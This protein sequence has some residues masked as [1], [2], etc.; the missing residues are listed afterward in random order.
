MHAQLIS[1]VFHATVSWN[2]YWG[3]GRTVP[4]EN[5]NYFP[6]F[7]LR[8]WF[9]GNFIIAKHFFS[10]LNML[11]CR[12]ELFCSLNWLILLA[13]QIVPCWSR[14]WHCVNKKVPPLLLT[15]FCQRPSAF[16]VPRYKRSEGVKPNNGYTLQHVL[17]TAKWIE[18]GS[19]CTPSFSE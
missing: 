13:E 6:L 3:G 2:D 15:A 1:D 18:R 8:A 16:P 4:L 12:S 14:I 17:Q 19:N 9:Q 7:F 10:F 11:V 5:I